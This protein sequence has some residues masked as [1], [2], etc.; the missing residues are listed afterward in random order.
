M[1]ANDAEDRRIEI[2]AV[3]DQ[4]RGFIRTS[5]LDCGRGIGHEPVE[6]IF[7]PF[8]TTKKDG[9]GLGLAVCRAIISAH[10]GRLWAT[11]RADS[12]AAFHFTL[13]LATT[14]DPE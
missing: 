12:G 11:N 5:V 10:K 14:A 9:L 6:R 3:L 1:N 4:A 13:P 7:E 2:A 8:F